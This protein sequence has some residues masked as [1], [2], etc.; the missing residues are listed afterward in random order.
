M[1]IF[2][3][4]LKSEFFYLK[5]FESVEAQKAELDEYIHYYNHH[6]IKLTLN[7]LSPEGYRT[8]AAQSAS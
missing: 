1:E 2:F 3:G 4:A 7:S 5:R 8:Q 6:R